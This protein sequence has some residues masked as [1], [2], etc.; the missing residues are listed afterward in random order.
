[1]SLIAGMDNVVEYIKQLEEKNKALQDKV[2]ELEGEKLELQLNKDKALEYLENNDEL[3]PIIK[4]CECNNTQSYKKTKWTYITGD[5]DTN[6]SICDNIWCCDECINKEDTDEE[7]N[8]WEEDDDWKYC[9][10]GSANS[11]IKNGRYELVMAGGGSHW[12]NYV[13]TK[14]GVFIEDTHGISKI[15]KMLVSSPDGNYLIE[16]DLD[17]ELKDEETNM[18]ECIMECYEDEMNVVVYTDDE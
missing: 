11:G 5:T 8:Y 3:E 7:L 6:I 1:M 17:Y 14:E 2:V 15:N 9:Y 13:I 16:K 18:Y 12:W 4:C 10:G